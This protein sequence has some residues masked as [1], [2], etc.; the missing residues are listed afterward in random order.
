MSRPVVPPSAVNTPDDGIPP[1]TFA[2]KSA[3]ARSSDLGLV[4]GLRGGYVALKWYNVVAT[5][6]QLKAVYEQALAFMKA[7]RTPR[8]LSDRRVRPPLSLALQ[9][10]LR[11]E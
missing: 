11:S 3:A 9:Q 6:E 1:L 5:D 4:S 10:W 8:L 2:H 7:H